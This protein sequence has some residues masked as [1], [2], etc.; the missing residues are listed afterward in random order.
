MS[1][2]SFAEEKRQSRLSH[3]RL[4]LAFWLTA[5]LFF[6]SWGG[7]AMFL[8]MTPISVCLGGVML[9]CASVCGFLALCAGW[10]LGDGE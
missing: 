2:G 7:Y 3:A 10:D 6:L 5:A 8:A 1:T 9:G 4:G